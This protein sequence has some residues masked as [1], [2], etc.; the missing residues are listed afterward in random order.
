MNST[1]R[2]II[3]TAVPAVVG[4]V[5]SWITKASA[6]LTPGE[7]AVVFPVATTIYY[8]AIRTAENKFPKLS[9]LLGA[10]PVK[11]EAHVE[12]A[13]APAAPVAPQA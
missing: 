8:S 5:A 1:I 6:H 9:W 10:L 11:A 7:T 4:A 2:N 12:A 13:V 3:R